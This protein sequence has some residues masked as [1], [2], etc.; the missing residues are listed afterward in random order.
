VEVVA[1]GFTDAA[2]RLRQIGRT[3]RVFGRIY[4]RIPARLGPFVKLFCRIQNAWN[5]VRRFVQPT[6]R[7]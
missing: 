1:Y 5:R 6:V 7:S 4:A 3:G 2:E